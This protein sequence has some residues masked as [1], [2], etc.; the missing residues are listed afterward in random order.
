MLKNFAIAGFTAAALTL[1]APLA[2]TA[3]AADAYVFEKT[4]A[5]VYFTY[6]HLGLSKSMGTFG[7]VA[8]T[9]MLDE[10]NP[11][12]SSV[13]VVIQTG[14]L[15]TNNDKRDAHL[16]SPDFFDV[17]QFPTATFKSTK[18]EVT[19]D[20]TAKV[21]GDMTIHGV[22]KTT[23]LDMTFNGIID[24]PMAKK[25]AAGFSGYTMVKR[26]DFG[27]GAYAPAVGDEVEIF[28]EID[29]VAK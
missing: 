23:V 3:L 5:D 25:K 2:G 13:E 18:V 4:H 20:N 7:D 28:I 26:S 19:G 11:A 17:G 14:S 24:H 15:D 29:T 21:T 9:V 6:D 22:T 1:S 16:M 10:A 8:G 12:N 27:M